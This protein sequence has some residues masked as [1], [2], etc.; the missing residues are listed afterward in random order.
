MVTYRAEV[1]KSVKPN[2]G[3]SIFFILL[4]LLA[5]YI[6]I[7][8]P[9]F[10][11]QKVEV[12]GNKFYTT[13]KIKSLADIDLHKN[14]FKVNL[15][16]ASSRIR[17]LPM[18]REAEVKRELP[19]G[20]I[21]SVVE[22]EPVAFLFVLQNFI[23]LDEEGVYCRKSK[24]GEADL[25]VITGFDVRIPS[26]GQAIQNQFLT[27][28]LEVVKSLPQGLNN[29]L[30]EINVDKNKKITI[31]TLAGIQC[32]M[33]FSDN[34]VRKGDVLGQVLDKLEDREIDYIDLSTAD[35]PVIKYK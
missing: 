17:K 3:G 20:V 18:I 6:L 16:A 12:K 4:L 27:I 31:Y 5:V 29:T 2:L 8:S 15:S 22:R 7:G 32:R 24:V 19:S 10:E 26:E 34:I 1:K 23:M 14:I 11:I 35:C 21:I 28:A 9:F 25:P 33:G 13:E 30:S